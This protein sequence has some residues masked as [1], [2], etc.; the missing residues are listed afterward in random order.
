MINLKRI[1][2]PYDIHGIY[3]EDLTKDE[4]ELIGKAF[5]T[6]LRQK[7]EKKAIVGSDNRKFSPDLKLCIINGLRSAGIDVI[8]IGTVTS[9]IFHYAGIDFDVSAGIMVTASRNSEKYNGFK[10]L[11]GGRMLYG[12]E[13]QKIRLLAEKG[14]FEVGKGSYKFRSPVNDYINMIARRVKLGRRKVI[15]AVDCGS[16]ATGLCIPA[17]LKKLGCGVVPLS[18]DSNSTFPSYLPGPARAENMKLLI[19]AVKEHHADLG[20]GFDIDGDRLGV[21]DENGDIIWNDDLMVLFCREILPRHPHAD[22]IVDVECSE[23]LIQEIIRFGGRPIFCRGG[24]SPIK[25]KMTEHN[26]PFAGDIS[27]HMFFADE[28]YGYG[29]AVYAAAR[30]LRILTN[31]DKPL[32][33]LLADL[34]K[35]FATSEIRIP[36]RE[37][38]KMDI[39]QKVSIELRRQAVDT[40]EADGIRA[41][42]QDGWCLVCASDTESELIVRCEGKNEDACERIK[43]V[44]ANALKPYVSSRGLHSLTRQREG[45]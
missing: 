26:A 8:N 1:V 25:A 36:C 31:T 29:D 37:D 38:E 6:F 39:V 3:G 22:V 41:Y 7:G 20:L 14:S 5:G 43:Q 35:A 2:K 44:L 4:A 40:E 12:P 23:K 32:S 10:I 45:S 15:V 33:Q 13:L 19:D 17:I 27:G 30:L 16:G 11:Y 42:F 18:C 9:P 34:P 24:Y 21:V 28:Y